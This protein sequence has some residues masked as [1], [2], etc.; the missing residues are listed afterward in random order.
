MSAVKPV[1]ELI[2]IALKMFLVQTRVGSTDKGFGIRD[3]GVQPVEMIRIIFRVKFNPLNLKPLLCQ[4][5][6][7]TKT[8][9]MD[10]RTG[11]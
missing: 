10:H 8:V 1:T 11:F 9:R 3:N 6:I 5:L 7:G 2:E 4:G